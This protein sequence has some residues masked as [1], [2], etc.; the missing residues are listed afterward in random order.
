MCDEGADDGD[1]VGPRVEHRARVLFVDAADGDESGLADGLAHACDAF[2]SDRRVRV[3]LRRGRE[4]WADGDVVNRQ[5][6][7]ACGL[8]D[9]VR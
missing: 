7:G 1:R 5:M 3:L 2:E 8:L 4:D 6:R 9:A